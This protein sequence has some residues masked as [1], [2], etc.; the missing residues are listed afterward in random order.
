MNGVQSIL[1]IGGMILLALISMQFNSSVLRSSSAD[2]DNKV[3]LTSFSIADNIIEEIKSKSFDQ[4]T[5]NYPT[6]N[7]AS[8]TPA[9]DLGPEP[10]EVYKDFNDVD[11]FNGFKDTTA[12][13]YFEVYYISCS[14]EYVTASNPD[15]ASGTQTFYKKATVT[16]SS[17]FLN[18]P[19]SISSIY[20][21]K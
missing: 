4:A 2:F 8:L 3:Y 9:A 6:T 15:V 18:N 7:L 19:I 1:T 5:V 14:V 17:P 21:L 11:D 12:A 20:T 13:P 16:V 10:G